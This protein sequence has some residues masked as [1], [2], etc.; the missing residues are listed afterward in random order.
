LRVAVK[1]LPEE[2]TT[3]PAALE[4]FK[5]EA[6]AASALNHPHICTVYDVGRHEGQPFLVMERLAGQTLRHAIEQGPHA[7]GGTLR[8]V[9][10]EGSIFTLTTV[11]PP[12]RAGLPPSPPR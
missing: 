9:V 2:R 5:R 12:G 6:R 11:P 8:V 4:R 3:T 7:A 10:P 1:F